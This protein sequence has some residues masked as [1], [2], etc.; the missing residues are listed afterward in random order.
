MSKWR[1]NKSTEHIKL[2]ATLLRTLFYWPS[3]HRENTNLND[4]FCPTGN[5]HKNVQLKKKNHT[6]S[7]SSFTY[8]GR[9]NPS[10]LDITTRTSIKIEVKIAL[11]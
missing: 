7:S 6:Q 11:M 1:A 5:A 8:S 4:L 10:L 2:H 9:L 3:D